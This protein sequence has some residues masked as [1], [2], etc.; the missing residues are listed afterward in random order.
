MRSVGCSLEHDSLQQ[1]LWVP[2]IRSVLFPQRWGRAQLYAV[3]MQLS[4]QPI[5]ISE[6]LGFKNCEESQKQGEHCA[7]L[8]FN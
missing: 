1:G 6:S 4:Y 3:S 7:D 8:D 2:G 5:S